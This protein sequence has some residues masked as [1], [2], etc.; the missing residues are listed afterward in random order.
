MQR[1]PFSQEAKIV[2]LHEKAMYAKIRR[3]GTMAEPKGKT[4]RLVI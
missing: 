2:S 4:I 3:T 1:V